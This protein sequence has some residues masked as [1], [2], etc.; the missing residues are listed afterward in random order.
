MSVAVF[1]L[2]IIAVMYFDINENGEIVHR[3]DLPEFLKG[4]EY[5]KDIPLFKNFFSGHETKWAES[6]I[7]QEDFDA[8]FKFVD[9]F[10]DFLCEIDGGYVKSYLYTGILDG[11]HSAK[12]HNE[13]TMDMRNGNRYVKEEGWPELNKKFDCSLLY[14][15][16]EVTPEYLCENRLIKDCKENGGEIDCNNPNNDYEIWENFIANP[17]SLEDEEEIIPHIC[18]IEDS[19]VT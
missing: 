12:A 11:Q 1:V 17:F 19:E 15:V 18:W 6:D 3:E 2:L 13:M 7:T 5:L 4:L 16:D 9:I 10:Q 8:Q 14:V